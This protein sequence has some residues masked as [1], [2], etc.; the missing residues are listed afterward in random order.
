M[1]AMKLKVSVTWWLA[2]APNDKDTGFPPPCWWASDSCS[3]V[4]KEL[5]A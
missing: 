3:R 1:A 5:N 4:Y 2:A